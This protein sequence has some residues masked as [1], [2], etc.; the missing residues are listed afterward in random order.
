MVMGLAGACLVGWLAWFGLGR[1][2]VYEVSQRARLEAAVAAR[3]VTSVQPGRLT[4]S[5]LQIGRRVQAGDVL[6][7]L[8]T[9]SERLKLD[10]EVARLQ[11]LPLK[12]ATAR[13][14]AEALERAMSADRGSTDAA[15]RSA[16]AREREAGATLE[17]ADEKARRMRV[18]SATG[19]IS[20][21]EAFRYT[22]DARKARSAR[23]A[24]GAESEKLS[25]DARLSQR[26]REAELAA[27]RQSVV[28]MEGDLV[29]A[30]ATAQRLQSEIE[31]RRIRAPA[32]G[33]IGEVQPLAAGAFVAAGQ[34]LA[35]IIPDGRLTIVAEFAPAGALGRLQVG[36][37]A[38]LRLDGY[39]WAQYG[40]VQAKVVR[41]AGESRD[42][43]L[44]ADLV[45]TPG[46]QARVQLRHGMTG[47]AE[48]AVEQVSPA[49]LVLRASGQMLAPRPM[50]V[51]GAAR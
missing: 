11:T 38:R 25:F 12:I 16:R 17:F 2:T 40:V 31:A 26:E 28:T 6:V 13:T 5:T 48:V 43:L 32:D 8:D 27:L 1:V 23:E 35:T 24:L 7:E 19:A 34:K 39:P 41:V 3:D 49:A 44:R 51:A 4:V 46:A 14:Q 15:L 22:T 36:Q 29:A 47:A 10:E 37:T 33:V 50:A 42:G 18:L 30:R 21:I 9:A 20:D 45:A